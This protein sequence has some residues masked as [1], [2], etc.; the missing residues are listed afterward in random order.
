MLV[1]F[2]LTVVMVD[3]WLVVDCED[4][5]FRVRKRD[6]D[7][8]LMKAKWIPANFL[9]SF[10]SSHEV[11]ACEDLVFEL[12]EDTLSEVD[13]DIEGYHISCLEG[14]RLSRKQKQIRH[15]KDNKRCRASRLVKNAHWKYPPRYR[16]KSKLSINHRCLR[17][18]KKVEESTGKSLLER[19][20][21][22]K[23]VEV[24]DSKKYVSDTIA[25]KPET[26]VSIM[27]VFALHS[28]NVPSYLNQNLIE[29]LI[30]TQ[31]REVTPEDYDLLLGL[32]YGVQSKVVSDKH[33]KQLRTSK[34][35]SSHNS[36]V[37]DSLS[38]SICAE[39]YIAEIELKFLPCNHFFHSH[40]I[41]RW[42]KFSSVSCPLDGLPVIVS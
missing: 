26:V 38:C 39:N 13:D 18:V 5:D 20:K 25:Q 1:D 33:L 27:P 35:D 36:F 22:K 8:K 29:G 15:K 16:K 17:K 32:D 24:C 19:L 40:C 28:D 6:S 21:Y 12:D 7:G 23:I 42:L 41:D 4:S 37:R 14:I 9:N 30:N 3:N 10:C 34:V 31:T 2:V 11:S